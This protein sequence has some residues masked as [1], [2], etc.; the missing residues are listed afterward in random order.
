MGTETL[1]VLYL[2]LFLKSS[3]TASPS[4]L[5]PS[6]D[7]QLTPPETPRVIFWRTQKPAGA[8]Q[9]TCQKRK[10][11]GRIPLGSCTRTPRFGLQLHVGEVGA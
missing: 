5:A 9:T 2:R 11:Q 4:A 3:S 6:Q 1:L 8:G 10:L 7:L